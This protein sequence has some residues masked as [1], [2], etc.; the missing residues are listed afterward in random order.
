M[1][2]RPPT[3]IEPRIAQLADGRYR[4]R[5][6]ELL[7]STKSVSATFD[8]L[9]DARRGL[10]YAVEVRA[11]GGDVRQALRTQGGIL[12]ED[13]KTPTGTGPV[14]PVSS[15]GAAA[16]RTFAQLVAAHQAWRWELVQAGDPTL[17]RNLSKGR[18]TLREST[19]DNDQQIFDPLPP[20]RVRAPS[21]S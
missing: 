8:S 6:A 14:Q 18:N 2:A 15:S 19:F 10:S 21:R 20:P 13:G 16:G 9:G 5:T 7:G 11:A 12:P 1:S 17:R 4:V 3:K